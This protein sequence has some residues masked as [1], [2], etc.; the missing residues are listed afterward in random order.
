MN[1]QLNGQTM[2]LP[3][4]QLLDQFLATQA[5]DVHTPGIAIS[6]NRKIIQRHD[7]PLIHLCNGDCVEIVHAVQGG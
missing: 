3:S 1:I 4:H 7:W 5:I 2:T 6:I